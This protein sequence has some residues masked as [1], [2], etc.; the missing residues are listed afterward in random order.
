MAVAKLATIH[1][2]ANI[3]RVTLLERFLDMASP[4]LKICGVTRRLD[5]LALEGA[6]VDAIGVNFWPKSK[7][8][9]APDDAAWLGELAGKL[10]RVGVFVNQPVE[11][12]LAL[13]RDGLID[14][15]QLHGDE[16]EAEHRNLIAA[17]APFF[18]ALAIRPDGSPTP[19]M[20]A[21][22]CAV[23]LDA[24]APGVYGGTGVVID[25]HAARALRD[26]HPQMP[27]I[28][29]GGITA[30]NAS[31]AIAAVRPAALDTASG[32]ESAPGIKDLEK[33]TRLIAA[34]RSA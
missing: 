21:G 20:P 26:A 29:A 23:L 7:R 5:A 33:S 9:V 34:V 24:H 11:L 6:G 8:H 22:A 31:A 17:G 16:G 28:L 18:Q 12:S 3:R 10:L 25:W 32:V 30:G 2:L 27:V 19:P 1:T 13:W 15:I 4:S 14:V